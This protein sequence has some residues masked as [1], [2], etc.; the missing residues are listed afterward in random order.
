[1]MLRAA[2][3]ASTFLCGQVRMAQDWPSAK[4]AFEGQLARLGLDKKNGEPV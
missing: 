1:M 3:E 2:K 4:K